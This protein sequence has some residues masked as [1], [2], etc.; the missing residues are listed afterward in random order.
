MVFVRF[1]LLSNYSIIPENFL[2][3][4]RFMEERN[5]TLDIKEILWFSFFSQMKREKSSV[6][7]ITSA[8]E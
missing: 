4:K 2:D 3:V 5:K 6:V 8:K 7:L 1:F